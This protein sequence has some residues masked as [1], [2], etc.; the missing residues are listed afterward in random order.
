MNRKLC[1]LS[2][3]WL[4]IIGLLTMTFD[5]IG[6][7]IELFYSSSSYIGE[8][9]QIF[10]CIGRLAFPIF[11]F[12]LVQALRKS[13]DPG[14]YLLRLFY[15]WLAF[16]LIGLGV[17]IAAAC[18]AEI[19][20]LSPMKGSIPGNAFNDLLYVGIFLYLLNHKNKKLRFLC[21]L[22]LILIGCSYG[23]DVA[24]SYGYTDFYLYFPDFIR[25]DYS[26][27]GLLLGLGFYYAEPIAYK[28]ADK[29]LLYETDDAEITQKRQ[30]LANLMSVAALVLSVAI[31]YGISFIYGS[32]DPLLFSSIASFSLI[33]GFFLILYNGKRGYDAK[34]FRWA[35]Y[36]YY[37]VHIIIIGAIFVLLSL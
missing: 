35:T 6:L 21:V 18:G 14:K 11:I 20:V 15:M 5:H 13:K 26:L 31:L 2:S 4:K 10:R 16:F 25:A 3:F 37:P 22:P 19:D 34:W 28:I 17:F 8:V 29:A 7:F 30:G 36:L 12:L 24:C 1:V 27:Y 33:S 32:A 9:G 23:F